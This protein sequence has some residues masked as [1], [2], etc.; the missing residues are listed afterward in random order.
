MT[1]STLSSDQHGRRVGSAGSKLVLAVEGAHEAR[2][3]ADEVRERLSVAES[4]R[5]VLRSELR[6]L[7]ARYP[8]I[9]ATFGN[10]FSYSRPKN[11][12]E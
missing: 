3:T 7:F 10:P 1:P 4:R 6:G 12:N 11:D 5:D 2:M 8:E 9:R